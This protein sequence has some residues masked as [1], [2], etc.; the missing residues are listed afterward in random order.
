MNFSQA[1][2][3]T[4]CNNLKPEGDCVP[5][6]IFKTLYKKV[7][8]QGSDSDQTNSGTDTESA[9]GDSGYKSPEY[10]TESR[11]GSRHNGRHNSQDRRDSHKLS[12]K[13]DLKDHKK[14]Y[15]ELTNIRNTR[16]YK[17]VTNKYDRSS[18]SG[19]TKEKIIKEVG[20]DNELCAV[21][22]LDPKLVKGYFKV[23]GPANNDNL[24]S[25]FDI[26]DV[27]DGWATSSFPN[28]YHI[29]FQMIDFAKNR[30][31]LAKIDVTEMVKE[32]KYNCLG[33]V[34]NTDVST[35]PGKHWF[36]MFVDWREKPNVSVEYFNSSGNR[37]MREVQG[38]LIA[39]NQY[40]NTAKF[41]SKIVMNSIQ[42][43]KD[44]DTECGPYSLYYIWS[45]LHGVPYTVFDESRI[46]DAQMLE[47][48]KVLFR[49]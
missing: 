8:G 47:F 18:A 49:E 11:Y 38:W 20:C 29:Y 23:K 32:N 15:G 4:N 45:R 10:N 37:P 1:D 33:V 48:R 21:K 19:L 28:F 5:D 22:K 40:L 41:N 31:E 46:T 16:D 42:H 17:S 26:D 43:Q 27:L 34:L 14:S 25:N 6:E 36:C 2:K 35:G 39:T 9:D 7:K 12:S 44:S 30:T 13:K 3:Q 24:L